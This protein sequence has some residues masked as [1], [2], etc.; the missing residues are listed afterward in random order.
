MGEMTSMA[1]FACV[2]KV[3]ALAVKTERRDGE[4][5]WR[6]PTP[7]GDDPR[8]DLLDDL[9][10]RIDEVDRT[11]IDLITLRAG[12]ARRIGKIKAQNG[13]PTTDRGREEQVISNALASGWDGLPGEHLR[14][15]FSHLIEL[16]RAVQEDED[17]RIRIQKKG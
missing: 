7:G 16:C 9:R 10:R 11:V 5:E 13:M 14:E 17:E 12:L 6:N 2:W 3:V 4:S 8:T 15:V 1:L